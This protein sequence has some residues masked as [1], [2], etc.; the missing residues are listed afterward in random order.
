[1][2]RKVLDTELYQW[3]NSYDI[4]NISKENSLVRKKDILD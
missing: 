2:C 3:V 1:M 4:K